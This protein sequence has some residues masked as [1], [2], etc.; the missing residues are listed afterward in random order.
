MEVNVIGFLKLVSVVAVR[1]IF[2]GE[3]GSGSVVS[4]VSFEGDSDV[5]LD[6]V[7]PIEGDTLG[8]L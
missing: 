4:G 2:G 6:G 5:K 8:V 7:W 3:K 1:N